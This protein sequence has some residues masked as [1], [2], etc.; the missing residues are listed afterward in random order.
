MHRH[1]QKTTRIIKNQANIT[2]AKEI[3]KDIETDPT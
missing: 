3:N 1:Q 2:P